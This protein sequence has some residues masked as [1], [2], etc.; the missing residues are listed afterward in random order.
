MNAT[1]TRVNGYAAVVVLFGAVSSGHAQQCT[2][3]GSSPKQCVCNSGSH[4]IYEHTYRDLQGRICRTSSD[5]CLCPTAQG[6]SPGTTQRS[7]PVGQPSKSQ[8][9]L[10]SGT[11]QES[12]SNCRTVGVVLRCSSCKDGSGSWSNDPTL[13]TS[14]CV[15]GIE[16]I[17]GKLW[18]PERP[19]PSP[20]GGPI[21]INNQCQR[22]MQLAIHYMRAD[23]SG[24]NTD[25][26][27]T[28][29]GGATNLLTTN[30]VAERTNNRILYV[31]A[32][33][34]GGGGYVL[35]GNTPIKWNGEVWPMQEL[36]FGADDGK[37]KMSINCP[38]LLGQGRSGIS[39]RR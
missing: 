20:P 19:T 39:G 22:P 15:G 17:R 21:E 6:N 14:N 10:P 2:L 16:N 28:I 5:P 3:S 33:E 4:T 12:C 26:W 13:N 34:I 37:F 30:G 29:K 35:K 1:R 11:Y 36:L 25:G 7:D 18:C 9:G 38:D 27:W 23:R 31:Y 24:W 8:G 32:V